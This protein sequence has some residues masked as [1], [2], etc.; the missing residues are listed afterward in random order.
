V[1]EGE[2]LRTLRS[3]LVR[4]GWKTLQS[5]FI[6]YPEFTRYVEDAQ[7]RDAG[8]ARRGDA[9]GNIGR[10]RRITRAPIVEAIQAHNASGVTPFTTPG[11]KRGHGVLGDGTAGSGL[12][13]E[14]YLEDVSML[15]GTDDRRELKDVQGQ[16]EELA[17]DAMGADESY[18]STNG[19]SLTL[20][21]V[22]V[23]PENL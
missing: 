12:G 11:H 19:S 8:S 23:V 14:V 6:S 5:E 10:R 20:R 18:F 15:N 9:R 3:P 16:A 21:V 7:G 4:R 17:A 13:A 2:L 1:R 22:G